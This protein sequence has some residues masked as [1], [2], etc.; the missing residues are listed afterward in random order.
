MAALQPGAKAP[1]FTLKSTGGTQFSLAGALSN[2]PVLLAFFK[3]SCP[4]CQYAF[5]FLERM[6][7]GYRGKPVTV[8]GVSQNNLSDTERFRKEF[9]ISFPALLDDPAKYAVSNAYG[10]TNV[11]TVFLIEPDGTIAATVVGWSRADMEAV[12]RRL[13][14]LVDVVQAPLFRADE[15][16]ADWKA[17]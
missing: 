3:V 11:P 2:G 12:N 13:A 17:G 8:A 7:R 15:S 1:E 4:V 16:V 9:E 14:E 10:L 6:H 5:P